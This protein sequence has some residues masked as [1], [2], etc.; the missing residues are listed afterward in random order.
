MLMRVAPDLSGSAPTRMVGHSLSIDRVSRSFGGVLAVDGVSLEVPRGEFLTLLGPSGS[1]KT[2]LLMI[3]AGFV[4]PTEGQIRIDGTDVTGLPPER[5][6]FGMVFQGYALFPHMS[7]AENIAYPLKVRGLRRSDIESKV[8]A[9][10]ALVHLEGFADRNPRHL[11]GGQQQRVALARSLVFRPDVVLL[12]EPLGALDRQ[13]RAEMQFELTALQA[14]LGATFIF[15]THDQDEALSMSDRVAVMN[16]GRLV[17]IGIPEALYEQP[18]TRFVAEFLGKSNCIPARVIERR[19]D[20][21]QLSHGGWNFL[22]RTMSA[23][24]G[25]VVLSLRPEK[26]VVTSVE[27]LGADNRIPGHVVGAAYLGATRHVTVE[28]E[29]LGRLAATCPA[30]TGAPF[31]LGDAAWVSWPADATVLLESEQPDLS[32]RDTTG[33]KP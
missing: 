2:T 11:S 21:I 6:N 12:D 17:Q 22:H 3:I 28:T 20:T 32:T 31:H 7:V 8:K 10:L 19:G 25:D 14:E 16:R 24:A 23:A 9:V 18:R 33:R 26:T 15:V 5:R 13:L 27:P 30:S 29:V 1:G 4:I